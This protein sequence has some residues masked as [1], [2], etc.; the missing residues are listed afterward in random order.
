MQDR[1]EPGDSLPIHQPAFAA[2]APGGVWQRKSTGHSHR[3]RAKLRGF[4]NQ[5]ACSAECRLFCRPFF[6]EWAGFVGAGGVA[7]CWDAVFPV[8]D[9]LPLPGVGMPVKEDMGN[10]GSSACRGERQKPQH[11]SASP[12][13]STVNRLPPW[14]ILGHYEVCH[15]LEALG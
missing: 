3:E 6:Q 14:G 12:D 15:F 13:P 9:T 11:T 2:S 10:M 4:T 5:S 7:G 8:I 1:D